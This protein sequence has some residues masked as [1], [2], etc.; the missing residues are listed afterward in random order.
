[1]TSAR[2]FA[3]IDAAGEIRFVGDVPGG[4]ACGCFCSVCGSPLIARHGE[5]NTWHFAHIAGQER[6]ACLVGAMNLLRRLAAE[7]L[8]RLPM[9]VLPKFRRDVVKVLPTR[10]ASETVEWESQPLAVEWLPPA[11]QDAPVARLDLETE[12]TAELFIEIAEAIPLLRYPTSSQ[13]GV[14]VF[15]STVP[16]DSDL[17]KEK[18]ARQHIER[19][20]RLLWLHQP[21]SY[22]LIADA[23][24]RLDALYEAEQRMLAE[25]SRRDRERLEQRRA[26]WTPAAAPH[27]PTEAPPAGVP[28]WAQLKKRNRPYFGYRLKDRGAWVVFELADGDAA[29]RRIDG[30]SD[31][32]QEIQ[33][34]LAKYDAARDV[35][36]APT[37]EKGQRLLAGTVEATRISSDFRDLLH[38]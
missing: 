37:F 29:V 28:A 12:A 11:A 2:I 6:E 7:H 31:W 1:L 25:Q 15:W 5:I 19:H 38:L 26:Q 34:P 33:D 3:A 35:I 21:D 32:Y 23:Q 8:R 14:L 13:V 18:Y 10:R 17:R 30:G 27:P 36:I 9:L 22:G 4:S 16:V 20:A 24:R